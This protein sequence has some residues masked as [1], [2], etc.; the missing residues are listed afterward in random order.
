MSWS[1]IISPTVSPLKTFVSDGVARKMQQKQMNIKR[2]N[3]ILVLSDY[4][5]EDITI[6]GNGLAF[7]STVSICVEELPNVGLNKHHVEKKTL[8]KS[9]YHYGQS[10]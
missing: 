1:R 4:G 9:V 10:L 5:S 7:I 3:A 8:R 6:L 2:T